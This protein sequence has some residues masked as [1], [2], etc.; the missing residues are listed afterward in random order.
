MEADMSSIKTISS[1]AAATL[2]LAAAQASAG[3]IDPVK[4]LKDQ[5]SG[6]TVDVPVQHPPESQIRIEGVAIAPAE[7][8]RCAQALTTRLEQ[9]FL[10]AGVTVVD[11]Q[12]LD[13]V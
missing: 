9:A 6:P 2:L 4:W 11:R 8:R 1:V 13:K 5:F 3:E 10:Q 7:G 12:Q